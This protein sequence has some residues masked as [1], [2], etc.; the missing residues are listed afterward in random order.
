MSAFRARADTRGTIYL[1]GKNI[2]RDGMYER[3]R[4]RCVSKDL[5]E[6]AHVYQEPLAHRRNAVKKSERLACE[7]KFDRGEG[8]AGAW[9]F[10]FAIREIAQVPIKIGRS[11]ATK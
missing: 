6:E 5:G 10:A 9:H 8:Y 3:T 4:F 11:N 1:D 7:R 2:T